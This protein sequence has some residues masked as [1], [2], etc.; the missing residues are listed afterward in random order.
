[1]PIITFNIGSLPNDGQGDSLREFA[2][3]TNYNNLWF[4]A[5]KANLVNGKISKNELP[6][7]LNSFKIVSTY[8]DLLNIINDDKLIIVRVLNDENKGITNTIYYLYPDGTRM[9][10]AANKDN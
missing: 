1:M 8:S 2:S 6:D 5:N 3:G 7:N 9:W 4:E 10:I